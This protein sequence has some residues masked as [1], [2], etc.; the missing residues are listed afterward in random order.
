MTT[1]LPPIEQTSPGTDLG[2]FVINGQVILPW[3][4]LVEQYGIEWFCCQGS[5]QNPDGGYDSLANIAEARKWVE[6]VGSFYW[7]KPS[8]GLQYML[9][10]YSRAI[11]LELPDFIWIDA[12]EHSD[13]VTEYDPALIADRGHGVY[14]GLHTRYPEIRVTF[15]SR[16]DFIR[17]YAP[18]LMP[19]LATLDHISWAAWPDYGL[20]PYYESLADIGAGAMR[21]CTNLSAPPPRSYKAINIFD[22]Q[23]GPDLGLSPKATVWTWQ[24]SSRIR[25]AEYKGQ[26]L[27]FDHG[28]DWDRTNLTKAQLLKWIKFLPLEEPPPVP[29][30]LTLESLDARLAEAEIQI[31]DLDARLEKIEALPWYRQFFPVV[32]K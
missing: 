19:L 5:L 26:G 12:E 28:Y 32:Q 6:I 14:D 7:L 18:E 17:S 11:D 16:P 27:Q 10:R 23:H 9:D 24:H 3:Q 8:W 2:G 29:P 1:P 20:D 13:G 4:L 21:E 30:A 31:A 25:P 22:G 15:Y